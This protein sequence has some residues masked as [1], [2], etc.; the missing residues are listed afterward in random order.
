MIKKT[1]FLCAVTCALLAA[2]PTLQAKVKPTRDTLTL[3][4]F[5]DFHGSFQQTSDIPGAAAL[6][7]TIGQWRQTT[8]NMHVLAGGDNYSGGYFTRITG[9][10]PLAELFETLGVEYSA[11]GNHEFDWGIPA[12]VERMNW[13]STRYL[14]ANIFLDTLTQTR[15]D[16]AVPYVI[17]HETLKNGT[18]L[19][20]AFIGLA[21]PETKT[22]AMPAIVKD[23]YFENPVE[24][25][26][27]VREQ[28]TDS[29]DVYILLTH[30]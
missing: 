15:P 9:G 5:N 11:I 18:P 4:G 3:I 29:A 14:C 1:V 24:C 17:V 8:P 21:T 16:W 19:R 23:L 10:Q 13:G 28:L 30:I 6:A 26:R 25:A 2:F 27:R 7:Y 20:L 12:M 22:T